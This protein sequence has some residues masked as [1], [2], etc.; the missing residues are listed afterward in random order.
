MVTA[1]RNDVFKGVQLRIVCRR[2]AEGMTSGAP[3]SAGFPRGRAAPASA[4]DLPVTD[5]HAETYGYASMGSHD[6]LPFE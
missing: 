5:C 2:R 4:T 3:Q 1:K 6:P